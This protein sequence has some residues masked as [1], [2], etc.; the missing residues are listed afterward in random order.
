LGRQIVVHHPIPQGDKSL[1]DTRKQGALLTR[2]VHAILAHA[3]QISDD[4]SKGNPGEIMLTPEW[5][6]E[7]KLYAYVISEPLPNSTQV[8]GTVRHYLGREQF[9]AAPGPVGQPLAQQPPAQ[10]P[11]AAPPPAYQPPVQPP[12]NPAAAFMGM[13]GLPTA[14][15]QPGPQFRPGNPTG[16]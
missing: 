14:P 8:A 9:T 4:G 3:G 13:G 16:M 15:Q 2:C 11:P 10:Q 7:K 1:E 5:F 6:R 12:A